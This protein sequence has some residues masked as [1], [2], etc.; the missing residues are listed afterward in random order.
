V[1]RAPDDLPER[2]QQVASGVAARIRL[3]VGTAV[4][5]VVGALTLPLGHPE[6]GP[7]IGWSI[8]ALVVTVWTWLTV[9]PMDAND[10]AVHATREEPGRKITRL[11]IVLAA[12]ASLVGIAL[13]LLGAHAGHIYQVVTAVVAVVSVVVS[14]LALHTLFALRY[15]EFY[16]T[17]ANGGIDFKQDEPPRYSDFLYVSFTVGMSF[18]ISD[19]DV[20]SS[21]LRATVLGHALLSYLFGSIIVAAVVNLVAGL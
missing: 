14:W 10:T 9:W 12:L 5:V 20:K 2:P 4:G 7:L 21:E 16:Y 18:A 11:L 8:G 17:G 6:F 19:T 15:A 1:N 13:L 3:A